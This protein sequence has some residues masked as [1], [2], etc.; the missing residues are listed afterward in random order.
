MEPLGYYK[1]HWQAWRANRR[2]Q[3][4][5]WQARGL[6]RELLDEFWAEGSI[7]DDMVFMA[8]VCGCTEDE[9]ATYWVEISHCFELRD[10]RLYNRKMDEQRTAKDSHRVAMAN[11]GKA[12]AIAKIESA[13][14]EHKPDIS[15]TIAGKSHIER[16]EERERER[17]PRSVDPT[18]ASEEDLD[19]TGISLERYVSYMQV[20]KAKKWTFID[21]GTRNRWIAKFRKFYAEGKDTADMLEQ[22]IEG[23]WQ[24]AVADKWKQHKSQ[25][26]VFKGFDDPEYLEHLAKQEAECN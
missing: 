9:M 19:G 24:G 5:S 22:M 12:G 7:P 26:V 20:R 4:M 25:P 21:I 14:A 23:R 18:L 17:E 3:R 15:Q 8:E 11:A 16:R 10:D 2:V 6:Y 1:W 13:N